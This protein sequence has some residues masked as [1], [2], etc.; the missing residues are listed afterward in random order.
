[1]SSL[2]RPRGRCP[3]SAR[4]AEKRLGG[5]RTPCSARRKTPSSPG[6]HHPCRPGIRTPEH[7]EATSAGSSRG[8][9]DGGAVARRP[10][11]TRTRPRRSEASASECGLDVRRRWR[12]RRTRPS[13][14]RPRRRPAPLPSVPAAVDAAGRARGGGGTTSPGACRGLVR[15]CRDLAWRHRDGKGQTRS[16]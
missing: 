10:N 12:S 16:S 14:P 13:C 8:S 3:R 1:M 7:G 4:L 6:S 9:D 11:E 2:G 5:R 15:R